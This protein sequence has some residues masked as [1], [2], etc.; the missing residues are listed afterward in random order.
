VLTNGGNALNDL[1]AVMRLKR[2][3]IGGL[4][5]LVKRYQDDALKTAFLI[6]RDQ[7]IAED[8]VQSTF[9][10]IYQG[11]DHFDETRPFRPYLLRSIA[12]AA[13]HHTQQSQREVSMNDDTAGYAFEDMLS[14]SD[15]YPEAEAE[16]AELRE[17]VWAAM[18]T[19]PVV[20]RATVVLRYFAGLSEREVAV[21]LDVP[22]GTVK[23]RL[24]TARK[25]L[26]VLLRQFWTGVLG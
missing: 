2:G 8:I 25:Q 12:N 7:S 17:A 20:Q 3:D 5:A 18:E 24:H 1:K 16:Q 4:E 22:A 11:I 15:P 9:L 21:E 26:N 6:V 14:S 23:W 13:I 10:R 19:L